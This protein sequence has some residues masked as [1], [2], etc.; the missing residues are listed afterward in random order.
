[1]VQRKHMISE[2]IIT[3]CAKKQNIYKS[4][5]RGKHSR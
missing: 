3:G 5:Y 1:V 2:I 4:P